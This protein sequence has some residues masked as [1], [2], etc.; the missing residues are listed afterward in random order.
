[1]Q[2]GGEETVLVAGGAGFLGSWLCQRLRDEGFKVV[3]VDNLSSGNKVNL[4]KSDIEFIEHDVTVP[5]ELRADYIFHL[6]SRASPKDFATHQIDILLTNS[7]GTYNLLRL[8]QRNKARFLVA[9]SSEVYGD[10]LESPQHEGYHGNVSSLGPRSCYDEGKRFSEALTMAFHRE[11][12]LDTRI[13]RIFNTYGERMR[14][15]DGRVIP[16]F[17]NQALRNAPIT[18]YGDGTQTRSFCY[19]SDMVEGLLK[20]MF[21]DRLAGEVFN[22]GGVEETTILSIAE[23]VRSLAGSGSSIIFKPLPE[24]DPR[25]RKPDITK[26]REKL[27]WEPLNDLNEGLRRT[28]EYFKSL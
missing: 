16:T 18:V 7:L 10:P 27:K 26:A 8:A 25:R 20:V 1:M 21:G 13:A 28:I 17:I 24:D 23:M 19:V 3:C 9:S 15:D 6:A 2:A 4:Y 11:Y 12:D 22:L 5:L 14:A